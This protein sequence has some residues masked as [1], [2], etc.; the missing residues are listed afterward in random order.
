MQ[1]KIIGQL[2]EAPS[3]CGTL[4]GSSF[5]ANL[6]HDRLLTMLLVK[7]LSIDEDVQCNESNDQRPR[8]SFLHNLEA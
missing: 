6:L 5:R 8:D 3:P 1:K 7:E 4:E 2:L